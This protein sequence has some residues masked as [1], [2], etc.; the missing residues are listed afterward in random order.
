MEKNWQTLTSSP[1]AFPLIE[2]GAGR[3]ITRSV[4]TK[5]SLNRVTAGKP[6]PEIV[7]ERAPATDER[8]AQVAPSHSLSSEIVAVSEFAS[9]RTIKPTKETTNLPKYPRR[10]YQL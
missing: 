8:A 3:M 7:A 2:P 4:V 1:P 10:L 6:P 9:T 5:S